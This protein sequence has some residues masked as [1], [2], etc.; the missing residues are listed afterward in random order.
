MRIQMIRNATLRIIYAGKEFLVDPML[1]EAGSQKPFPGSPR[2]ELKN[3]LEDLPVPVEDLLHPDAVIVTHLHRDH[4]DRAAAGLLPGNIL[5]YAQNRADAQKIGAMGFHNVRRLDENKEIIYC[6]GESETTGG[7]DDDP[8]VRLIRTEARHS[9]GRMYEMSGP[10]CGI[11]LTH[12]EEKTL[13]ITGDTVWCEEV[14]RVLKEYRPEVVIASCGENMVYGYEPL[15]MGASGILNIHHRLPEAL[16]IACHM[17]SLN[18]WLLS[19]KAL[20]QF[21]EL[22]G[23]AGQLVIPENGDWIRADLGEDTRTF[24]KK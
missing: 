7:N 9:H 20:R 6:D 4:F 10:A 11:V 22:Y 16:I 19:K 21:S 18:H 1:G 23:F 5:I 8:A 17:E 12:P 2:Q 14:G 13:Y 24:D 15:I 3:P